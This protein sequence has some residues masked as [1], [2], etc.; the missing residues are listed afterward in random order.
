M[1][2][3]LKEQKHFCAGCWSIQTLPV[4]SIKTVGKLCTTPAGD[5][6]PGA[7]RVQGRERDQ[8]RAVSVNSDMPSTL[9]HMQIPAVFG[10]G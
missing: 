5:I 7:A 1:I 9:H 8:Q 4:L 6:R 3:K 10:I 2:A